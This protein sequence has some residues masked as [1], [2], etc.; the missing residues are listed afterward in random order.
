MNFKKTSKY[1]NTL[2][3]FE[4]F[5]KNCLI[6]VTYFLKENKLLYSY[7]KTPLLVTWARHFSNANIFILD[8]KKRKGQ[9]NFKISSYYSFKFNIRLD[10]QTL[11]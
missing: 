8:Q 2:L 3:T 10:Y 1:Q 6:K 11:K 9:N 7:R 5:K 4:M